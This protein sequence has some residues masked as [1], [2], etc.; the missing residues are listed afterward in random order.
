MSQYERSFTQ[1][2][3]AAA[4]QQADMTDSKVTDQIKQQAIDQVV[5]TELLRQAA[6][7]GGVNITADQV[8][9]R[10]QDIVKQVGGEEALAARMKEL[11][12]TQESLHTDIHDELLIQTHLASAISTSSI[13]VSDEEAKKAYDTAVAAAPKGTDIPA[14]TKVKP[15][16]VEQV[17]ATKQQ[18]Q[19]TTYIQSLKD[20]AKIEVLI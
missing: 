6:V 20:K 18:D 8:E 13:T 9:A 12:V 1:L 15:A 2:Q 5:N 14:F 4:S 17:R 19:I 10:Y 11:G 3:A 7:A 16:I